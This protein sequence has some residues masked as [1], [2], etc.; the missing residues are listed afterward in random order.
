MIRDPQLA[1]KVA[2]AE[3]SLPTRSLGKH[4]LHNLAHL[5]V[6]LIDDPLTFGLLRKLL[7]RRGQHLGSVTDTMSQALLPPDQLVAQIRWRPRTGMLK[8]LQHRMRYFDATAFRTRCSA[9]WAFLSRLPNYIQVGGGGNPEEPETCTFWLFPMPC[10]D[11]PTV[12]HVLQAQGFN[13]GLV[14]SWMRATGTKEETPQCHAFFS[15]LVYLPVY[16]EMC[17]AER[18]RLIEVLHRIPRRYV[19]SPSE[20]F[21][22]YVASRPTKHAYR[23]AKVEE[24][25]A[26]KPVL[27][28]QGS[29][30]VGSAVLWLLLLMTVFFRSFY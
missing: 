30:L 1:R 15:R 5:F 2:A 19:Q 24:V 22:K 10:E 7:D 20:E 12:L 18:D 4:V 14:T 8:L 16:P 13:A 26:R 28:D 21:H 29:L 27:R 3:A 17:D 23:S 9:G 6:M 11:P 25:G